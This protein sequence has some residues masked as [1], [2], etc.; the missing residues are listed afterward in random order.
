TCSQSN[1]VRICSDYLRQRTDHAALH[2][3][4][5]LAG[6][7]ASSSEPRPAAT[8]ATAHHDA[9]LASHLSPTQNVVETLA[10][11]LLKTKHIPASDLPNCEGSV[12]FQ[13]RPGCCAWARRSAGAEEADRRR[14]E[15]PATGV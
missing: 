9:C 11:P 7:I 2:R 3:S 6:T 13:R 8:T 15:T 4:E 10:V 5:S 12:N 1:A 14:R